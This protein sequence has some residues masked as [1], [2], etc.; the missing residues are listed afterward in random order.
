M[1]KYWFRKFIQEADETLAWCS[2]QLFL[3]CADR[4]FYLWK[5]D[6]ID[7][8]LNAIN[9]DLKVTYPRENSDPLRNA[10]KNNE[11]EL[12]DNFLGFKILPN[13][14]WP[15]INLSDSL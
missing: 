6:I 11:K 1:A 8:N 4:R 5:D 3:K 12:R 2:F 14:V 7:D 9:F 10:I 13:Q 15:W